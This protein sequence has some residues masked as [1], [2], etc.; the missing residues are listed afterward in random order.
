MKSIVIPMI[1]L[2]I[3][4]KRALIRVGKWRKRY[5]QKN[6]EG[7]RIQVLKHPSGAVEAREDRAKEML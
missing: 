4:G 7:I 2:N 6:W 1:F 5:G 3:A